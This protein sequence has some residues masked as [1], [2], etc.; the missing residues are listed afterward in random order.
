[1]KTLIKSLAL[2]G[3]VI[4][5]A[6]NI[7][8][9]SVMS[10]GEVAKISKDKN[11]IIISTRKAADYAKVHITGAINMYHKNFYDNNGVSGQLKKPEA[12]YA[13][14]S[15]AGV[16]PAKK[17][18]LYDNKS[19]KYASRVYW[20]LD[21]LG[22]KDIH[23][24]DGQ[25]A[26]WK[27]NRKPV[28]S[29]VKKAKKTEISLNPDASK[30]ATMSEV[31]SAIKNKSVYL[32]DARKPAEFNGQ[33]GT[34]KPLG[35]IPGAINLY[36]QDVVGHNGVFISKEK[37][38]ALLESK[39]IKNDKPIIVYCNTGILASVVYVGIKYVAGYDNV[40][41]FDGSIAMWVTDSNNP[42]E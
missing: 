42:V 14:L 17:I 18:I 32:V 40:K 28:T 22:Y 39:G 41:V 20:I 37:M 9:Q 27:A 25:L 36:Y 6:F 19:G 4:L 11:V 23:I 10:V 31:K 7:P 35:H 5:M 21:Y 15:K 16:D 12:L 34:H 26:A 8:T 33:E 2:F 1:M 13:M 24:L 38:I 30:F 3:F 29:M